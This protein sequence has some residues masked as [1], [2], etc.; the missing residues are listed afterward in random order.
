MFILSSKHVAL[1]NGILLLVIG[2]C[3]AV[4][5]A[6]KTY[7]FVGGYPLEK[8]ATPDTYQAVFLTNNQVYFGHLIDIDSSFPVLLDVYY[9]QITQTDTTDGSKP[10]GRVIRLGEA[11]PHKPENKMILNRDHILFWEDLRADSPVL[12]TIMELKKIQ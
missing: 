5:L 3:G 2:L 1:I 12:T 9:V 11:E 6:Y 4:L 8:V 7:H 10:K